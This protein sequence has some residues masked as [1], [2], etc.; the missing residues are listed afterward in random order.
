MNRPRR[1]SERKA[2]GQKSPKKN[3]REKSPEPK[4]DRFRVLIA[5]NRPRYRSRSERAVDLPGWE[6]RSL[7]NKEDPIGLINQKRPDILIISD[8]FGRNKNLGFIRAAQRWRPEGMRIIALF[9]DEEVSEGAQELYDASLIP[10]W[11]AIQLREVAG[12]LYEEVRG[13]PAPLTTRPLEET[14]DS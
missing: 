2:G 8:D 14:E 10:P 5:V 7:T 3:S 12:T 1:T 13:E 6:V 4:D 11:K 9:E